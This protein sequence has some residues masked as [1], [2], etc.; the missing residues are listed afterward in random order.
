CFCRA[1]AQ[2]RFPKLEDRH[3]LWQVLLRLTD[4]K[5]ADHRRRETAAKRGGGRVL[6]EAALAGDRSPEG[7]SPLGRMVSQEPSPEFAALATEQFR[8]VFDLL[9]DP[10][11][12]ESALLHMAGYEPG[13]IAERM[14]CSERTVVRRLRLVKHTWEQEQ[15]S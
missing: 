12:E 6:D 14:G 15:S 7:D 2:G 13:E 9:R 8:R 1:A 5:A 10:K 4:N 11:L 3:D